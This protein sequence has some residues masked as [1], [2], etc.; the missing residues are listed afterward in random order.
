VDH[1]G[2][3]VVLRTEKC[4]TRSAAINN[5]E[6]NIGRKRIEGPDDGAPREEHTWFVC[7]GPYW[8]LV[9]QTAL[10]GK[11]VNSMWFEQRSGFINEG[12]SALE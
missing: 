10:H 5:V 11:A 8:S 3:P 7:L 9:P 2:R 12:G 6:I 1:P 4:S